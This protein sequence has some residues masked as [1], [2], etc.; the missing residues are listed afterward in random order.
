MAAETLNETE[1]AKKIRGVHSKYAHPDSSGAKFFSMLKFKPHNREMLSTTKGLYVERIVDILDA[2]SYWKD[3]FMQLTVELN[4][5]EDE[6][7]AILVERARRIADAPDK[8]LWGEIAKTGYE[9]ACKFFEIEPR[10]N[11]FD[12]IIPPTGEKDVTERLF[13]EA[14]KKSVKKEPKKE[15]SDDFCEV[16]CDYCHRVHVKE[17][18]YASFVCGE[19]KPET[20]CVYEIFNPRRIKTNRPGYGVPKRRLKSQLKK[21]ARGW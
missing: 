7:H 6:G 10:Q 20:G 13:R 14:L 19:E 5:N 15:L 21:Q 4:L 11:L 12:K 18:D 2:S 17:K 3:A 16:K 8:A 1:F 9:E